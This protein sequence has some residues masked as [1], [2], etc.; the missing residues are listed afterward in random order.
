VRAAKLIF[1][2]HTPVALTC[3]YYVEVF[4]SP[5]CDMKSVTVQSSVLV[6]ALCA[7]SLFNSAYAQGDAD[8][9]TA[10][11]IPHQLI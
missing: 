4:A 3:D 1:S 2:F 10:Q 7:G 11:V 9:P 8:E 5:I 6:A